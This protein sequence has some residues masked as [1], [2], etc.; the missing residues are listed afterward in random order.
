MAGR[1]YSALRLANAGRRTSSREPL[2]R[3]DGSG[4]T[5]GSEHSRHLEQNQQKHCPPSALGTRN[6]HTSTHTKRHH[7]R[8]LTAA[9]FAIAGKEKI[10][11]VR[12]E[13]LVA[14]IHANVSYLRLKCVVHPRPIP[15]RGTRP[16]SSPRGPARTRRQARRIRRLA[17]RGSQDPKEDNLTHFSS[18]D[19]LKYIKYLI[20]LLLLKTRQR[21]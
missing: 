6:P 18:C 10:P 3:V 13:Y 4:C 2:R 20:F 1:P 9:A 12:Q 17:R 19:G 21:D 7:P 16:C 15:W 5:T 11:S 14:R 8:S